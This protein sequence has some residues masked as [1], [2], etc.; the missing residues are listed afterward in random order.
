MFTSDSYSFKWKDLGDINIGRPNLGKNT[1]VAI[2]RLMQYTMRSVLNKKLG[3]EAAAELFYEAGKLAGEEF[4]NNLL[5]KNLEFNEFISSMHN[6]M[7]D[8]KMANMKIEKSDFDNMEFS[9]VIAEDLDC[10]GLPITDETVCEYDEGFLAGVLYAYTGKNFKVVETD[11]W[12]K[13][14]RICRFEAKAI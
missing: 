4:C 1:D 10:S 14:D 3:G 8:L 13:G 2:Y 9:I 6:T 5:N 12:S 11:C 7:I